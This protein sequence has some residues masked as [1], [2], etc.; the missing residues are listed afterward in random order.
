MGHPSN[1]AE[2]AK[3]PTSGPLCN[4]EVTHPEEPIASRAVSQ[5]KGRNLLKA[6]VR[7]PGVSADNTRQG[8]GQR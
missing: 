8:K 7:V 4:R 6:R 5:G 2:G 1:G 3:P